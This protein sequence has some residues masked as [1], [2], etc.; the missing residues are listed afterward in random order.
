V[1]VSDKPNTVGSQ[2]RVSEKRG[3][4]FGIDGSLLNNS[5]YWRNIRVSRVRIREITSEIQ[6]WREGEKEEKGQ[7]SGREQ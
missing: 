5:H 1:V 6:R 4:G 7:E 3:R 2:P